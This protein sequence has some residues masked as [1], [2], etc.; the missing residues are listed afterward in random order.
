MTT[1]LGSGPYCYTHCLA[2]MFG[3]Q[4]P[5]TAVIETLTGAPFGVQLVAGRTPYFDPYGWHPELGVADAVAALGWRC[6]HHSGGSEREALDRLLAAGKPVLAGPVDMGLLAYQTGGG[7]DHY[8]LVL[9][10][11]EEEVLLHDP[12]GHPYATLPTKAFLAAWRAE[13]VEYVDVPFGMRTGFVRERVVDPVVALRESL[14]RAVRW[15]SGQAEVTV[16]P[17]SLGGAAALLRLAELAGRGLEPEVR[18][19]LAHFAIRLGAR[20]LVD[21]ATCLDLLGMTRAATAAVELARGVGGLQHAVVTGE[22][23]VLAQRLG[24]LAPKYERWLEALTEPGAAG[25]TAAPGRG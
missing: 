11:T 20:R 23:A 2:M 25:A 19:L 3:D 1:Y 13:A 24:A 9:A 16:P 7:G 6:E 8:V 12:H 15:L 4:A 21:A 10:A 5:P 18:D 22:N 17:G 14:P